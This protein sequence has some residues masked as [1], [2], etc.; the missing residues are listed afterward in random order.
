MLTAIKDRASG[1]IAWALVFLISI[2]FAL[3]G[4]NSYFEGASKIVVA[5]VNGVD[6]DEAVYQQALSEQRR[7]LVQMMG[8]NVDA[9][10]FASSP[11]KLEVLDSLIDTQLQAEYLADRGYRITNEQLSERIGAFPAFQSEGLFDPARYEMLLQNA[12]LSAEGFERQQRQQG[13]VDQLRI[14]LRATSLVVSAMTDRA[15][16]LLMQ[17]R[18][19]QFTILELEPF[20]EAA[21]INEDAV[22]EEYEKHKDRYIQ[23]PQMQVDYLALSLDALAAQAVVTAEAEQA[24]YD[25]NT[26]RFTQPGSRTASH[27][28]INVTGDAEEAEVA[29][30]LE[31]AQGLVNQ[32]RDGG[33]FASLAREYSDDPG[34]AGRGGDL[35]IIRPGTMAPEFEAVV[36]E[37]NPGEISNPVRTDYG[38]HVIML[39]DL[40]KS[41]VSPFAEVRSEIR[42]LLAREW[43]EGQFMVMAEDFQNMV[44]EQPGSLD[45]TAD[46]LGL[47]I[48]RSGWFSRNTG[49]GVASHAAVRDAAFSEEVRVDRLNSE[50]IEIDSDLLIAV[51]FADFRDQRQMDLEDVSQE[52]ADDLLAQAALA[53]QEETADR[54]M[55]QLRAGSPWASVLEGAGLPVYDLP[56]DAEDIS[57]PDDQRVAQAVY[58]AP[59]PLAGQSVYGGTRLDA[60]RYAVYRLAEVVSGNP[61]EISPEEREQ[62][63]SLI[64]ARVGEELYAGASRAL[65]SAASVEVF[66]E[67]L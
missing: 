8:R 25:D 26:S 23:P 20:S 32:G 38:W 61:D 30:A 31:R 24:F 28:L 63:R 27:I 48:Q 57:D 49:E 62:F 22:L 52:I 10:F 55:D 19:A 15:I 50:M 59:V 9:E 18:V 37:L 64:S 67:N 17:E 34:S 40:R 45:A 43:A 3:W 56:Q 14:G 21:Q 33:D 16:A 29:K 11:F 13:A 1:W 58:A 7:S 66:E 53:G 35:G 65:R 51:H 60:G 44:F 46:F 2:P 6:V 47:P 42:S 5:S 41:V 4:I 39:T 36:F 12:G 54:M